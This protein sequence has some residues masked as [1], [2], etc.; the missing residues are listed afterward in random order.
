LAEF[1]PRVNVPGDPSYIGYSRE[2]GGNTSTAK[3]VES[4]GTLGVAGVVQADEIIQGQVKS[5]IQTGIADGG[6]DGENTPVTPTPNDE[7]V[8]TVD[9]FGEN[10][11]QG[12][13]EI[14]TVSKSAGRLTEAYKQGKVSATYYWG[15]MSSLSKQLKTRYPG[16]SDIIDRQFQ[17]ITGSIPAT[18]L[19][20][21]K[22]KEYTGYLAKINEEE[23]SFSRFVNTNIEYLP[24]DYFER[25]KAGDPYTKMEVYERVHRLQS[26]DL[27]LKADKD[28]L[29]L[30]T[31]QGNLNE[32][33][34]I[35]VA[36][37]EAN[38]IVN[39]AV[40]DTVSQNL[41]NAI[42]TAV[43]SAGQGQLPSPEQKQQLRA[44]YSLL[45]AQVQGRVESAMRTPAGDSK[46]TYYSM[47]KDPN[48]VQSII[49][50][51][52]APFDEM[53]RMLDDDEYGLFAM[54]LNY[55]KAAE[56]DAKGALLKDRG[57]RAIA[58]AK[59]LGGSEFVAEAH[60]TAKLQSKLDDSVQ[61]FVDYHSSKTAAGETEPLIE[62]VQT[63][64]KS[65]VV[66]TEQGKKAAMHLID[67]AV[68]GLTSSK[69][70]PTTMLTSA[71]DMFQA[72]T[73]N[74]LRHF[75]AKTQINLY[76]KLVSPGVTKA[77]AKV[78]ETNPDLWDNYKNWATNSFLALQ[79]ANA[80]TILEGAQDREE[81]DVAWNEKSRQFEV[82]QT[83]MG[84]RR[85]AQRAAGTESF[86]SGVEGA[87][88]DDVHR[89]VRDLNRQ[90]K[91]LEEIMKVDGG[92]I[93]KQ[94]HQIFLA[95]N[96]ATLPEK[97]QSVFMK[98]R[99]LLDEAVNPPEEASSSDQ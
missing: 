73:G 4:L 47:I 34:A 39:A 17:G 29:A 12:N 68:A 83:A 53:Q 19:A 2:S 7:G 18:A 66:P 24:P 69:A 37:N 71:R 57:W 70:T 41:I 54:S 90:I 33:T 15:R 60:F 99:N 52:M 65:P 14:G 84:K 44:A 98:F 79:N 88:T 25:A 56:A 86:I 48:K 93:T 16:Y 36:Q 91:L 82:S 92:D 49:K 67:N 23:K 45:R 55:A 58:A 11:L 32:E 50:A 61:A 74:F 30:A 9:V 59:D 89:A 95:M 26:R 62:R 97:R 76:D 46:E 35:G 21:A 28:R 63:V 40:A 72:D 6:V 80:A 27:A 94:L 64:T 81:V 20:N 42:G 31:S 13:A 77:M 38:T 1:N 8:N 43:R 78:R 96:I 22:R 10:R 5:D 51:A 75:G 85:E 3:L 87:F